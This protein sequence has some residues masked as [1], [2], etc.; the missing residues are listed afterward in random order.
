MNQDYY[1][2]CMSHEGEGCHHYEDIRYITRS[3]P[4]ADSVY[5]V[6]VRHMHTAS[7]GLSGPSELKLIHEHLLPGTESIEEWYNA[8]PTTRD[9]VDNIPLDTY[10]PHG[11]INYQ[12][13]KH[14]CIPLSDTISVALDDQETALLRNPTTP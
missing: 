4:M 1:I 6:L 5:H 9:K 3:E 10:F 12:S 7:D 13:T 11:L 14:A 8:L 2:V